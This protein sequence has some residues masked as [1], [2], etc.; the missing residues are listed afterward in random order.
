MPSTFA[1]PD[2]IVT[3]GLQFLV[4]LELTTLIL[5]VMMSVIAST[6]TLES[7]ALKLLLKLSKAIVKKDSTALE[8][9]LRLD[10]LLSVMSVSIVQ[11]AQM[12]LRLVQEELTKMKPTRLSA[13]SVQ[14]VSSVELELPL[15]LSA[16]LD[17]IVK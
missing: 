9:I 10:P 16:L 8:L 4:L 15:T 13:R 17:I 1:L 12:R 11:K 3:D 6:V 5:A 2:T 7:T 14:L